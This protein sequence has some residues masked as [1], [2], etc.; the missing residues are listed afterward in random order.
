MRL[1]LR[2]ERRSGRM[3]AVARRELRG[4]RRQHRVR[5]DPSR[6]VDSLLP[7]P[8]PSA[9]GR[10]H[11]LGGNDRVRLRLPSRGRPGCMCATALGP[12]CGRRRQHSL[13]RLA[14]GLGQRVVDDA[15]RF[16]RRA[17]LRCREPRP[18]QGQPRRPGTC[19]NIWAATLARARFPRAT[20][21]PRATDRCRRFERIAEAG[22]AFSNPG[23]VQT[24]RRQC[25]S[26]KHRSL[27]DALRSAR[28][29]DDADVLGT[30]THAERRAGAVAAMP[31]RDIEARS[32]RARR[33]DLCV[34]DSFVELAG[35]RLVRPEHRRQGRDTG[36]ASSLGY[37]QRGTC[38]A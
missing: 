19:S 30:V 12:V 15:H 14:G 10:V 5:S 37:A 22:V 32:S 24:P 6:T 38:A 36:P 8:S 4:I 2:S 28:P 26:R 31:N 29:L 27:C 16:C 9:A 3:C 18:G 11:G 21:R 7:E 33:C 1:E 13:P 17:E 34:G 20:P 25:E 23:E 35:R